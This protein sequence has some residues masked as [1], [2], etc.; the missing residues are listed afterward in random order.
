MKYISK[1]DLFG[2]EFKFTINGSERFR[3]TFGGI[4]TIIVA[5]IVGVLAFFFGQDLYYRRNP[6]IINE[7]KTPSTYPPPFKLTNKNLPFMWRIMNFQGVIQEDIS[8]LNPVLNYRHLNNTITTV[9]RE[10]KINF[11]PC[12]EIDDTYPKEFRENYNTSTWKCIDWESEENLKKNF[13]LGGYYDTTYT[14]YFSF[15]LSACKEFF[16]GPGHDCT[17]KEELLNK[18]KNGLVVEYLTIENNLAPESIDKPFNPYFKMQR[19]IVSPF[20]TSI[21]S[22]FIQKISL[23]DDLGLLFES[24]EET[25][26]YSTKY[27]DKENFFISE[28]T[29]GT[30][31]T[32]AILFDVSY[33]MSKPFTSYKRSYMRLQDLAAIIGGIVKFLIVIISVMTTIFNDYQLKKFLMNE[34]FE[35]HG[36][37]I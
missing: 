4:L 16:Y 8:Y 31:Y 25:N 33:F 12:N 21:H 35:N 27:V 32:D 19:F 24:I 37:F 7:E 30:D 29:Q 22:V 26:V 11:T 5:I 10:N 28:K 36:K 3:S 34:L 9:V 20:L 13:T 2:K 18:L 14:H 1:I 23:L 6:K 17:P 15:Y